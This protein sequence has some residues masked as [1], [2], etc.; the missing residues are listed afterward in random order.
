MLY[1]SL[2][3]IMMLYNNR[4]YDDI[5]TSENQ[6]YNTDSALNIWLTKISIQHSTLFQLL[7]PVLSKV[8]IPNDLIVMSTWLLCDY[9]N[10]PNPKCLMEDEYLLNI[11]K[12]AIMKMEYQL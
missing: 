7:I 1:T 5:A 9:A 4:I 6:L 8:V 3:A 10:T 2:A 11:S 12:Y